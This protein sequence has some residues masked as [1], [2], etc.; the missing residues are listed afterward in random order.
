MYFTG[1][2]TIIPSD[3]DID[4]SITRWRIRDPKNPSR[5]ENFRIVNNERKNG[6]KKNGNRKMFRR[7][8]RYVLQ[9]DSN[10]DKCI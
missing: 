7:I 1:K 9:S 4:F 5:N 10:L 6:R 3:Y 2:L 8:E